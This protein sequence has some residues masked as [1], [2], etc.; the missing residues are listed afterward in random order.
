M[1]PYMPL[2]EPAPAGA[3]QLDI[4]GDAINPI[5]SA[6]SGATK[7]RRKQQQTKTTMG[8]ALKTTQRANNAEA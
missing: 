3:A 8:L 4:K 6:A 1:A 5:G 2:N 7:T